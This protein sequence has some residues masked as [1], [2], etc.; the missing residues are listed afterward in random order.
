MRTVQNCPLIEMMRQPCHRHASTV[1]KVLISADIIPTIF[2]IAANA[3]LLLTIT[4]TRS[5]HTPSNTLL[6]A[7]CLSDLLVGVVSQP[8][9]LALMLKIELFQDPTKTMTRIVQLSGMILNGMSFMIVLYITIERYVAVCYPYFYHTNS[10]IKRYCII[11][12]AT[13]VYKILVPFLCGS[14][15]YYIYAAFTTLSFAVMVFCYMR[16][17]LVIVQKERSVLRLGRIG[18]EEKKMLQRNRE[19]RSK[20]CTILILLIV[21]TITYLPALVV[22]L[23]NFR[24]DKGA[25]LC[26][27]SP[28]WYV[29]F[30]W[31]IFFYNL[32]SV[33][34]PIV[35]CIRIK[36]IKRGVKRFVFNR[37]NRINSA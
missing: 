2:T 10:S 5:L 31:C 27:L 28:Q 16:I 18:D 34:N 33:I 32:S 20:A 7:L 26:T 17:Y 4:K 14:S 24:P 25:Y 3:I 21:F 22:I 8:V 37:T 19:E 15:Y 30:M 36:A 12:V 6:A 9:H 11:L 1:M 13:W 29:I 35:Y 23:V